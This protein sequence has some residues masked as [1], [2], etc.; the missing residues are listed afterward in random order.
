MQQR[1]SLASAVVS[2]IVASLGAA[3][4]AQAP[5][6]APAADQSAPA[7]FEVAS[8]K[9]NKSGVLGSSIRRQPGGG[10]TA[11][12]MPLRA[13]ITFAYQLQPYQLVGDPAWI[14]NEMF[15]IVAKME[16]NPAP[17]APFSGRLDPLM[18][19][20]QTLLAERFSLTAHRDTQDMDIYALVVARADGKLGPALKPSSQDCA[21]L[22]AA[23]ARGGPPPG[24]GPNSPVM[25]G[26][27][28]N[29]GRL[30]M[31]GMP[32]AAFASNLSG[33]V[34]RTV[35]DRTGL[36]GL[37]DFELSFAGERPP[38]LP[39][40]VE[41]PPVDP[42]APSLFTAIQE[43]LGLRL[44]ATKGP[45]DVLVVDRVERPTPD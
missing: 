43:Q 44:Q 33:M 26:I 3:A 6:P 38:N 11:T 30:Q 35:V 20:M 5:A 14:R 25:C 16:G 24:S 27:R 37:W 23:V 32:L 40:G 36:M 19:A 8:V 13:L 42:G 39:P 34:Q 10:L 7:V 31:G 29:F 15:D 21:A 4:A 22:M 18:L 12:N 28:G 1:R 17:V 2:V 41:P 45:V 9:P